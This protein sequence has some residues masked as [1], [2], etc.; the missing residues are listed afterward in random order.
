MG[1]EERA[2][3]L[4]SS[5][6]ASNP[7]RLRVSV[8]RWL[9]FK[10]K[11]PSIWFGV[12]LLSIVAASWLH[13]LFWIPSTLLILLNVLYW[14]RV[15]EHF[16][17]GDANPGLVVSVDPLLVAV[18]TDLTQGVGAY[19]AVKVFEASLPRMGGERPEVGSRIATVSLYSPGM[20]DAPH[21]GDFIPHPAQYATG[22]DGRIEELMQTFSAGDWSRL[23]RC[24]KQV[25]KPY[26][27]GLYMI[28]EE[29]GRAV[30]R[31]RPERS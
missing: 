11:W 5:A 10:P 6:R 23:Q 25:P 24:L 30:A 26:R 13:W 18:A 17:G 3:T 16:W 15:R 31:E 4:D 8:L 2:I 14:I 7:G 27:P 19:P 12:G 21:W 29:S 9:T 1:R 22:D 28:D 20:N